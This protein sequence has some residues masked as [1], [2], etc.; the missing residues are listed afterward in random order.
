MAT[1]IKNLV[2]KQKPVQIQSKEPTDGALL[3]Q[4]DFL[5]E[6][7]A[8][9]FLKKRQEYKDAE[10]ALFNLEKIYGTDFVKSLVEKHKI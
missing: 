4:R 6:K 5:G 10:I 2:K 3:A 9:E 8:L 7:R 1:T